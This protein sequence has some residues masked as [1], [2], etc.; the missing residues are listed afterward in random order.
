MSPTPSHLSLTQAVT[1]KPSQHQLGVLGH[2]ILLHEFK[3]ERA[4][5]VCVVL[6]FPVQGH[7]QQRCEVDLGTS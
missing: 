4:H 1:H 3:K 6:Q 5:D 2:H 7:R